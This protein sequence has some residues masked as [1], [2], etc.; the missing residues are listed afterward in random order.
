MA[1]SDLPTL[2]FVFEYNLCDGTGGGGGLHISYVVYIKCSV[3]IT[4]IITRITELLTLIPV[5]L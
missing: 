4:L 5:F 1:L 2:E 3:R